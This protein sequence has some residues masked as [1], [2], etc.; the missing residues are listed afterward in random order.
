M[1]FQKCSNNTGVF[2][3]KWVEGVKVEKNVTLLESGASEAQLAAAIFEKHLNPAIL[4]FI[5]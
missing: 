1:Y 2:C 4:V 5:G 3:L